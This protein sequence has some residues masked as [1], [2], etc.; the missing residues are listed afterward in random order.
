MRWSPAVRQT[1]FYAWDDHEHGD[2]IVAAE[3]DSLMVQAMKNHP[4]HHKL[5][6]IGCSVFA[7]LAQGD[8]L[9]PIPRMLSDVPH[10]QQANPISYRLFELK[11]WML[12][13]LPTSSR[14]LRVVRIDATEAVIAGIM[15]TTGETD[16][17]WSYAK[18]GTRGDRYAAHRRT[19]GYKT[20][21]NTARSCTQSLADMVRGDPRIA[22]TVLGDRKLRVSDGISNLLHA[23]R[24]H[25]VDP[26]VQ[27]L[28]CTTFRQLASAADASVEDPSLAKGSGVD[29]TDCT[30]AGC[31]YWIGSTD[32]IAHVDMDQSF[33]QAE[34]C[35]QDWRWVWVSPRVAFL[36]SFRS[37]Q[38]H[39]DEHQ[40]FFAIIRVISVTT[41][42]WLVCT[43]VLWPVYDS[44]STLANTV[45]R[46]VN[47]LPDPPPTTA[48]S[49]SSA[50][51]GGS[52]GSGGGPGAATVE[53]TA[54]KKFNARAA[55]KI[56]RGPTVL[57]LTAVDI[58][59]RAR[60]AAKR[61]GRKGAM[62]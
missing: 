57:G 40:T 30:R 5:Q 52:N 1:P 3:G 62:E 9:F 8:P 56:A 61:A 23:M 16:R 33:D 12:S 7:S 55:A 53:T 44:C 18:H 49:G 60:K 35:L 19:E 17:P 25:N 43:G 15:M 13:K 22:R 11:Q 47:G 50:G 58:A 28:G 48:A 2:A 59:A 4:T 54:Q 6:Q 34:S 39:K 24:A 41:V 38:Q 29:P 20:A 42:S 31:T 27:E 10:R 26:L 37:F 32:I 45:Y 14:R 21:A 51:A 36:R 46:R